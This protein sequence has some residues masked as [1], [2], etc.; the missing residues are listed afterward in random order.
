MSTPE[1]R[2]I[3]ESIRWLVAHHAEQPSLEIVAARVRMNPAHFS[4]TFRDWVG[5]SPKRFLAHLTVEDLKRRLAAGDDL[6]GAATDSGLSSLGRVHDHFVTLEAATPGEFRRGGAG[7]AIQWGLHPTPFGEALVA[8]T[9]RGV[10]FLAFLGERAQDEALA[11]LATTWPQ[12]TLA[13]DDAATAASAARL[14]SGLP[15]SVH[16]RGTNF[17]VQVWRA[18]LRIPEGALVS[19]GEIAA[20]VG[21]PAA[22]RAVGSAVGANP[23][24]WLVP[25]H[26]VIRVSGALGG[27]RWGL[28]CKRS[29]LAWEGAR[30][31]TP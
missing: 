27:Y 15:I 20:A 25:C 13:R 29:L 23:V 26:R 6:V 28:T 22:V 5:V 2:R 7:L 30:A 18:L 14:F 31:Q 10:C 4:R 16:V 12:A 3:A 11:E 1:H 8:N 24:S 19:Y 9:A 21:R 17:Q